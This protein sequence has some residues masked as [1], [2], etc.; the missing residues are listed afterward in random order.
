MNRVSRV[1]GIL[2]FCAAFSFAQDLSSVSSE[3]TE[4]K[5][6]SVSMETQETAS[7]STSDEQT[8]GGKYRALPRHNDNSDTEWRQRY[9]SFGYQIAAPYSAVGA[10]IEFGKI[11]EEGFFYGFDFGGGKHTWSSFMSWGGRIQP[12]EWFQIIP[13]ASLGFFGA[14]ETYT[15]RVYYGGGYYGQYEDWT[16]VHLCLVPFAPFVKVLFGRK[17]LWGEVSYRQI[18]GINFAEEGNLLSATQLS[19]KVVRQLVK[20]AKKS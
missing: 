17:Q 19:F 15:R 3:Q 18:I 8:T 10:N 16:D 11:G 9:F 6:D 5:Q 12:I 20:S 4:V 13:G 7:V 1:L 14:T 2:A